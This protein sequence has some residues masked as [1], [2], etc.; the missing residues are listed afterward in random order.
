MCLYVHIYV[1][2]ICLIPTYLSTYLLT[3]VLHAL[4]T[5]ILLLLLFLIIIRFFSMRIFMYLM[6]YTQLKTKQ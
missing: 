2:D 3:Y 4:L 6:Y 1:L 5:V